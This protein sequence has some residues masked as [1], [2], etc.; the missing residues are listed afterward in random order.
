M[1]LKFKHPARYGENF[2]VRLKMTKYTGVRFR[3]EYVVVN[4]NGDV[5]IEGESG[6]AFVNSDQKPV[7]LARVIPHRHELMKKLLETEVRTPDNGDF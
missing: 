6:H 5:L 7:P 2:T 4:Q 3:M 1:T